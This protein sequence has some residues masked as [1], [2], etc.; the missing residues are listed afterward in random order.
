MD[1]KLL[2]ELKENLEKGKKTI[3]KEL[4]KI[5]DKDEKIP[6]DWDTR[7]PRQDNRGSGSSALEGA[8][9][10]V[11]EYSTLLPIEYSLEN[12]LKDI[13]SS[14]EKFKNGTYGKCEKCGKE[15]AEERLKIYPEAK[16]CLKCGPK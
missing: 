12:R 9:D 2:Q 15:I 7:Y 8:A 6:G 11:E 14:L 10:E 3:E 16:F 5:A 4:G 13:N 1:K